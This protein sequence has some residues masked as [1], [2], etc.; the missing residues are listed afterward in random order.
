[1]PPL[2]DEKWVFS[3]VVLNKIFSQC[4]IHLPSVIYHLALAYYMSYF[5]SAGF[6]PLSRFKVCVSLILSLTSNQTQ[7]YNKSKLNN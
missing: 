6:E 3:V 4:V 7:A 1:M 5:M 2:S